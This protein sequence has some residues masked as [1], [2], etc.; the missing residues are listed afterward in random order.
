MTY[1]NGKVG[2]C[3]CGQMASAH[4]ARCARVLCEAHAHVLPQAPRGVS[5]NAR[6]RYEI[7][8]RSTGQVCCEGC[9]A[10]AGAQ[11]LQQE[12][13]APRTQLPA[14]WLDRAI[15]LHRDDSRSLAE[16]LADAD[17]PDTLNATEVA[18]E[19]LRRIGSQPRETVPVTLAG[20]LR[21]PEYAQGWSVDCRRTQYAPAGDSRRMSLPCL[22][23]IHA[24]ILGPALDAA[25]RQGPVWWIVPE[26]DIELPRLVQSVAQLLILSGV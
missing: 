1:E 18:R 25:G 10:D 16:K 4:C 15:A 20:W 12:L 26:D 11:A 21:N 6:S 19:F 23:S 22:I 5:A 13:S 7:A 3:E 2:F 9:R 24:E 14:H 17:L 8:V